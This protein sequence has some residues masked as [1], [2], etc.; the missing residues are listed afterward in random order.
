M[1]RPQEPT[2]GIS[3]SPVVNRWGIALRGAVAFVPEHLFFLGLALCSLTSGLMD[4]SRRPNGKAPQRRPRLRDGNGIFPSLFPTSYHAHEAKASKKKTMNDPL[5]FLFFPHW[6]GSF[7][8]FSFLPDVPFFR[9]VALEKSRK[10]EKVA[11]K[12]PRPAL[13]LVVTTISANLGR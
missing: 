10:G 11:P 5:Y 4:A 9:S 1:A 7:V 8:P 6:I 12:E 13:R 2:P 3:Q